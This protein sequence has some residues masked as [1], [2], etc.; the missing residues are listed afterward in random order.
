MQNAEANASGFKLCFGERCSVVL[1]EDKERRR[2]CLWCD[3]PM[4]RGR[5][6]MESRLAF[7]QKMQDARVKRGLSFE[8]RIRKQQKLYKMSR[9]ELRGDDAVAQDPLADAPQFVR[10]L[11]TMNY[12]RFIPRQHAPSGEQVYQSKLGRWIYNRGFL[13]GIGQRCKRLPE[14]CDVRDLTRRDGEQSERRNLEDWHWRFEKWGE[15]VEQRDAPR[16]SE[17]DDDVVCRTA[18][19]I[20]HGSSQEM[21]SGGRAGGVDIQHLRRSFFFPAN[22]KAA[23]EAETEQPESEALEN[24]QDDHAIALALQ[25]ELDLEMAE[26]LHA[27][28]VA[29]AADEVGLT[30]LKGESEESDLDEESSM[31]PSAIRNFSA[32][33][34]VAVQER[35]YKSQ[36]EENDDVVSQGQFQSN[37]FSIGHLSDL[38]RGDVNCLFVSGSLIAPEQALNSETAAG[39]LS[40]P[41]FPETQSQAD[42]DESDNEAVNQHPLEHSP[43]EPSPNDRPPPY[44]G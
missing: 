42:V 8:T 13:I 31:G 7:D 44:A 41:E 36:N 1:E 35:K 21:R 43:A 28:F 2:I 26:A 19:E 4:L 30:R 6:S 37:K 10:H 38:G 17:Q 29:E 34:G 20:T 12:Q 25:A 18:N 27:E 32:E 11:D 23:D 40:K 14:R 22:G 16:R 39:K 9:R 33:P 5:A 24:I 3:K 15:R